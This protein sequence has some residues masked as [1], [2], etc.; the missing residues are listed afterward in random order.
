MTWPPKANARWQAGVGVEQE[1][2][3]PSKNTTPAAA[4]PDLGAIDFAER[5][6]RSLIGKRIAHTGTDGR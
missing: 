3:L 2:Q 1:D 5:R 6:Y 4:V